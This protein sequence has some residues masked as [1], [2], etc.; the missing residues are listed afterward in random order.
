LPADLDKLG[1][2]EALERV[3]NNIG[4]QRLSVKFS[5][6]HNY[7]PAQADIELALYRVTMELLNNII[8]HSGATVAEVRLKQEE[9]EIELVISDN[10]TGFDLNKMHERPGLGLKNIQGRLKAINAD[11]IFNSSAA[12][13]IVTIRLKD[14]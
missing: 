3:C 5:A 6:T 1:L 2:A 14:I 12:G 13:T 9:R 8:R 4:A 10:G 7:V 11:F